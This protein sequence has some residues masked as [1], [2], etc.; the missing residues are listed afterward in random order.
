M[1]NFVWE[2]VTQVTELCPLSVLTDVRIKRAE[3]QENYMSF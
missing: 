3:Y 2:R 1:V